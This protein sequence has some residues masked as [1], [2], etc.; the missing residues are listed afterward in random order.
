MLFVETLV[1]LAMRLEELLGDNK[2][3]GPEQPLYLP[4]PSTWTSQT[5][6]M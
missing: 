5:G 3:M 4:A 2:N 6:E 1:L